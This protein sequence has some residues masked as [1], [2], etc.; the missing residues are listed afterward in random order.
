M[1]KRL[2][3]SFFVLLS[4]LGLIL[5]TKLG[6]YL[7][8]TVSA[9]HVNLPMSG[10]GVKGSLLQGF[11][12]RN[13]SIK[14]G[15]T[16][17]QVEGKIKL[18]WPSQTSLYLSVDSATPEFLPKEIMTQTP[19]EIPLGLKIELTTQQ[20]SFN[21]SN[22]F[23]NLDWHQDWDDLG[24]FK[25][26][27][28]TIDKQAHR[29]QNQSSK[30][31]QFLGIDGPII[32]IQVSHKYDDQSY[33]LN[34]QHKTKGHQVTLLANQLHQYWSVDHFHVGL[35]RIDTSQLKLQSLQWQYDLTPH[36]QR[37]FNLSFDNL[38]INDHTLNHGQIQIE[39]NPELRHNSLQ[40]N[41]QLTSP[42]Q[43]LIK[44][45]STGNSLTQ[46]SELLIQPNSHHPKLK[47][48]TESIINPP[49]SYHLQQPLSINFYNTL[50]NDQWLLLGNTNLPKTIT[51]DKHGISSHWMPPSENPFEKPLLDFSIQHTWKNSPLNLD[52][53]LHKAPITWLFVPPFINIEPVKIN[54]AML[55]GLIHISHQPQTPTPWQPKANL[56]IEGIEAEIDLVKLVPQLPDHQVKLMFKNNRLDASIDSNKL[57]L[58]GFIQADNSDPTNFT[59]DL[60]L[61]FNTEPSVEQTV[62]FKLSAQGKNIRIKPNPNS[63]VI[64]DL[65]LEL[66]KQQYH[67][68]T[69]LAIDFHDSYYTHK[70]PLK[71]LPYKLPQEI[72]F[73]DDAPKNSLAQ[74][75]ASPP[76]THSLDLYLRSKENNHFRILDIT[77]ELQG[78]LQLHQQKNSQTLASGLLQAKKAAFHLFNQAIPIQK[79]QMQWQHTPLESAHLDAQIANTSQRQTAR[80]GINITGI[81]AKNV[82]LNFYSSQR[83]MTDYEILAALLFSKAGE[84]NRQTPYNELLHLIEQHSL[85]KRDLTK[86]LHTL[87]QIKQMLFFE[88]VQ[89]NQSSPQASNASLALI[90]ELE[91]SLT[92]QMQHD[93]T[94]KLDIHP[95]NPHRNKVTL[96][97]K[98]NRNTSVSTYIDK[99]GGSGI[100]WNYNR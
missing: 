14:H 16:L 86:S 71:D 87:G 15:L 24:Q 61:P 29:F 53:K 43:G 18:D 41:G 39:Y 78:H 28:L 34:I 30:T 60:L 74:P 65:R 36:Q 37:L 84:K 52:I 58:N 95:D 69:N 68:H 46:K 5:F 90:N 51:I 73:L 35:S 85:D 4:T 88:S 17:N 22:P 57:T 25:H 79:L 13:L 2:I 62:D 8:I 27:Q 7:L 77:G 20:L 94:V 49:S 32:S 33:K 10:H 66:S 12:V 82:Q 91:L 80:Y 59:L 1:L 45:S 64:A 99:S 11:T 70:S 100:S 98:I 48:S 67:M 72:K 6:V 42:K 93:M 50:L 47:L 21:A 56:L 75:N 97:K 55:T 83:Q 19:G 9:W 89:L 63:S 23:I 40:I 38:F 26:T 96:D 76:S 31:S 81:L 44:L 3:Q 92:R 54:Q